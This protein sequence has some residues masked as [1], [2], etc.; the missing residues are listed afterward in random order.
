[1]ARTRNTLLAEFVRTGM[2]ALIGA[3]VSYFIFRPQAYAHF[4]CDKYEGTAPLTVTCYNESQYARRVIWDFGDGTATEKRDTVHHDYRTPSTA[5]YQI[6]LTAF[7]AGGNPQFPRL[8]TVHAAA[9]LRTTLHLAL[10]ASVAGPVIRS[11]KS[12]PVDLV[13]DDHPSLLAPSTREFQTRLCSADPGYRV[14]DARFN[15]QSD[16]RAGVPQISVSANRE[17]AVLT[18]RLTSGP[19]TDQYRGW[20]RGTL[21]LFQ[22]ADSSPNQEIPLARALVATTYKLYPLNQNLSVDQIQA[23]HITV[24]GKQFTVQQPTKGFELPGVDGFAKLVRSEQGL[25]LQIDR[26]RTSLEH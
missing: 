6:V 21:E 12:C 14:V 26:P 22:E 23:L 17:G 11:T 19:R 2:A 15:V 4:Y 20:L 1:M 9:A 24:D 10:S 13:K 5:P 25:A 16:T 7:G 3:V 18:S 8:I